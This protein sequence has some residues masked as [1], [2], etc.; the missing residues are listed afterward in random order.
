MTVEIIVST[1]QSI[2]VHMNTWHSE[3]SFSLIDKDIVQLMEYRYRVFVENLEWELDLPTYYSDRKLECDQFD[4]DETIYVYSKDRGGNING[5]A[6]LLPTTQPYLLK[7]VFPELLNGM[8]PPESKDIWELSRFT[9]IDFEKNTTSERSDYIT[10]GSIELLNE[11][12][13]A[14]KMHGAKHLVS[15]SPLSMERLLRRNGFD[16]KRIGKPARV[17]KYV[18]IACWLVL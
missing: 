6:R 3:R 17:G 5:C 8:T 18:L 4:V 9:N 2:E 16:I 12:I 10:D 15:V 11:S 13:K 1:E 14:A 7:E